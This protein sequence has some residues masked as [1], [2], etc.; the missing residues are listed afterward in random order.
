MRRPSADPAGPDS[1]DGTWPDLEEE[2]AVIRLLRRE[3][4]GT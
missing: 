3:A 4:S 2:A 1:A